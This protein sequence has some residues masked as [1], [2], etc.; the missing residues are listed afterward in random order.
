[1]KSTDT[2][3]VVV[4][5]RPSWARVQSIVKQYAKTFGHSSVR[6]SLVGPA[7]SKRYGDLSSAVSSIYR[8]KLF[9]SLHESDS[10]E[11]IALSAIEGGS[12]LAR[13][14]GQ[15][16]PSAILVIA[17]RSETLAVSMTAALMQIPIIHLQG[18]EVSG[19][20]DDKVRDTNSKLADLHF[21]TNELTQA[22]LISM[23]EK[24]N[25]IFIIG[26][27]SVDLVK[28]TV[29]GGIETQFTESELGGVGAN[30]SLNDPF[31]IIMFHPDTSNSVENSFWISEIIK[32]VES[33][34]L[35]WF[36][37]WPNPDHGTE[38]ISK[39]IR[40]QRESG[41]LKNVRFVI[42]LPPEIFITLANRSRLL[43]GNSS[44]G[45][46]EASFLGLPVLNFGL[47]QS[48]RQ[49][50]SNVLNFT[51]DTFKG[52]L[53]EIVEAHSNRRFQSSNLYGEG[54]AGIKAVNF[55]KTWNPRTKLK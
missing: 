4:T 13:Y 28:E 54:D 50:A 52:N 33:S 9:P 47:R 3:E 8:T 31:G 16:R 12:A 53:G 35:K 45:I 46:R 40:Q 39:K 27:P 30:F 36:W 21:T 18:G 32:M 2:L 29:V 17:D 11:N 55:L 14:W 42:N 6:L 25:N 22:R 1:M 49:C 41:G 48:G 5:A 26:C 43:V 10:F 19:S 44:F 7:V 24:D 34:N 38:M 20:I 15:D 51:R 23:G 37:F